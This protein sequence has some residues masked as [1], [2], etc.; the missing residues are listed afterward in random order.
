MQD[1]SSRD[2][3]AKYHH[4][5]GGYPQPEAASSTKQKRSK[6][7]ARDSAASATEGSPIPPPSKRQKQTKAEDG[8]TSDVDES[9]FGSWVPKGPNWDSEI[10]TI[11]TVERDQA[12]NDLYILLL[13]K[14]GKKSRVK[15]GLM[16]KK[17]PQSLLNFYEAHLSV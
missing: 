3:L 10:K 14:N 17:A 5:I 4:S 12:S 15:N 16:R 8:E 11:E 7:N 1:R 13:F 6:S 9:A 2:L